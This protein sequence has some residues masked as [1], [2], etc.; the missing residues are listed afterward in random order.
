MSCTPCNSTVLNPVTGCGVDPCSTTKLSTDS[1]FYTGPTL[2][3]SG[4]NSCS[5]VTEA[6]QKLDFK[7]CNPPTFTFTADNGI[8]KT[9]NNIQLGGELIEPTSIETTFVNSL[10][11]KG[12]INVNSPDYVVSQNLSGVLT[13][14][15][16]SAI[17][18]AI[19]ANNGLTKTGNNIQ[20]G[21]ALVAPTTITTSLINTLTLGGLNTDAS[22]AFLITQAAGGQLVKT[23]VSSIIPI[24]STVTANNGLTKTGNNIQLGG[25]LVTPTTVT[26][27]STNTLSITGLSTDAAPDFILTE[28]NAGVVKKI[29]TST[30]TNTVISNVTADNGLTKTGNNIQFGGTLL[31]NTNVDLDGYTLTLR[32]A[33]AGTGIVITPSSNITNVYGKLEVSNT[34][35]LLGSVGINVSPSPT[36]EKWLYIGKIGAF[37][38]TEPT[39]SSTDVYMTMDVTGSESGTTVYA[40]DINRFIWNMNGN[41]SIRPATVFAGNF[42]YLQVTS[43]FTTTA[44]SGNKGGLAASAAQCYFTGSGV[45]QRVVAYRAFPPIKDAIIPYTGSIS[46]AIGLQIDNQR[47]FISSNIVESYGVKQL[48]INDQNFFNAIHNVFP[49]I[50]DY[51]DDAAADADTSLPSGAL[52]RTTCE[53]C[54]PRA[55]LWKP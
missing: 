25:A 30:L 41:Q 33:P 20:L 10:A 34:S 50:P 6:L 13:K 54:N 36:N 44:S 27:D 53:A 48:G 8:T 47:D 26:T 17:L 4:I 32:D 29:A 51:I 1:I 16:L 55:I 24:P 37:S 15:P 40:S 35:R 3:C 39:V 42:A 23:L 12:L 28:T 21:G 18:G 38:L 2:S 22:P 7:I 14:T 31:Q 11:I 45:T 43:N 5:T 49:N 19:T 52:Y 46:E 9:L